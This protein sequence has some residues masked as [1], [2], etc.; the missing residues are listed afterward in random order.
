MVVEVVS[1]MNKKITEN[2]RVREWVAPHPHPTN[3]VGGGF[4]EKS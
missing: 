1:T 4:S 2:I 3:P